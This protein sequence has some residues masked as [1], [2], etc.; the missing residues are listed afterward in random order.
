MYADLCIRTSDYEKAIELGRSLGLDMIGLIVTLKDIPP[1]QKALDKRDWRLKPRVVLGTDAS[2]DTPS[3]LR[4]TVSRLRK[5]T[6]IIVVRGGTDELNRAALEISEIDILTGHHVNG[7]CGINHVLA[8][9]AKKNNIAIAFEMS[10]LV[11][12]YRMGRIQEFSSME[13]TARVVRK[14]GAPYILTSGAMD[15]WDMRSRSELIALGKQLGFSELQS[16]KGLSDS[17]IKENRKRLSG[18]WVMP[19]VEIE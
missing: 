2:A 16:K 13:E 11:T 6:E 18:K 9:L 8:R 3:Q 4:R 12:S 10:R 5:S 14:Y 7:R 19:G 1:I 15:P 17:I